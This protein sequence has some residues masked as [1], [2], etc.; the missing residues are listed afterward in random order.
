MRDHLVPE[1]LAVPRSKRSEFQAQFI[2]RL[3][4]PAYFLELLGQGSPGDAGRNE[5]PVCRL[6]SAADQDI[7]QS[8]EI[9]LSVL[10]ALE[11][12]K[13]FSQPIHAYILLRTDRQ[14]HFC[15]ISWIINDPPICL[16]RLSYQG[17]GQRPKMR[18]T[19]GTT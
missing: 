8:Q 5:I 4:A 14:P 6:N 9:P 2:C 17:Q 12:D 3:L 18:L 1:T 7:E 11:F 13:Q 16:V 15:G 10:V 19:T